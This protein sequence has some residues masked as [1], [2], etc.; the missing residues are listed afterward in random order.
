MALK[1]GYLI[2]VCWLI[3]VVYSIQHVDAWNEDNHVAIAILIAFA[4]AMATR[5]RASFCGICVTS[6]GW[7]VVAGY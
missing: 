3:Y 6:S 2:M 7:Y 5:R 4:R 1:I